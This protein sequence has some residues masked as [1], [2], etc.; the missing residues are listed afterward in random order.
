MPNP[1]VRAARSRL[2]RTLLGTCATAALATAS[3]AAAS[4]MAWA[5]G[6]PAAPA[7]A[8]AP[9]KP[10]VA[11]ASFGE[12][13][14]GIKYTG[15][16]DAGI[17]VNPSDPNN[18][19]NFGQLFT[20]KANRPILNQLLLTMERDIDPKATSYDFG[21][22]LQGL[23]GS[24]ARIVHS[25]GLFDHAI[26]DRNQIDLLEANFTIHTPW[27]SEGGLDI[28]AGIY[29][30][31]LGF[32]LIDPKTNAFYSHSYIFN[33][34]LPYKHFGVLATWHASGLIDLYLGIDTGTNTTIGRGGDNNNRPGGIAGI[35]FNM[36]DG[37]LTVLALTHMGPE[38]S[39]LNTPFSNSAMRYYT[40]LVVTWKQSDKL[41]L[42]SELNYVRED[43][44]R[45]EGYGVA[46]YASYALTDT[47]TLNGR[48]ELWR[49][50]N[51]FFVSTPVNN[52][53]YVNAERGVTPANFYVAARPT[54]YS[55][56]T[57]GVTYKPGD[58][59]PAP[60]AGLAVRPELRYDRALNSSH[61][62]NDGRDYGAFTI[63]SD[64]VV[65]F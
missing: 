17:V 41:T 61:P 5:Q 8:A 58:L 12:W 52:L 13:A 44:F 32:E 45:A 9:D 43:G 47:L 33:Y 21:I 28:K 37:A 3:L 7:P 26:H 36:M 35:G 27:L 10:W 19:V 29:P 62:F 24:D 63:A 6:T 15:Q 34:G 65:P 40:D 16:V 54:T 50:N 60:L 46:G 53:D 14:S 11:P 22:K 51:N 4:G 2:A 38:D 30:T 31:P 1:P 48:A 25:L 49:D 23:Y 55:E 56:F 18:G 39:R 42:T 20:D 57:A 59:L 64:V